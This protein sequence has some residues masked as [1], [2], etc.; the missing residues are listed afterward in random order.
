M[1]KLIIN[2]LGAV[3]SVMTVWYL[4]RAYLRSIQKDSQSDQV[5]IE[6]YL[7]KITLIAGLSVYDTFCKSAEEW[8]VPADRIDRD[9][10]I[11]LSSQSVPYYVKDFVRK[12]Q[13]HIDE[14]YGGKG[15][16]FTDK[17]LLLFYSILTLVFWGGAVFVSL[18]V[19]PYVLPEEFRATLLLGPP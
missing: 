18:Y 13:K 14:L 9:F 6:N 8:R 11:Y 10:K 17:K 3:C 5:V 15:T 2:A 16:S 19:L 4:I 7:Q 12:G 1:L